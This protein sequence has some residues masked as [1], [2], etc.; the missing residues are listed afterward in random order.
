VLTSA[1]ILLY[2]WAS[3]PELLVAHMGGPFFAHKDE[4][5]WSIPKGLADPGEDHFAAA[6]REFGEEMGSPPPDADYLDLGTIRQS[7]KHVRIWAAE[8]EFDASTAVSN[9]FELEWP[10]RSGRIREFPE[11]DRAAWFTPDDARRKLVTSQLPFV[12]RL[13]AALDNAAG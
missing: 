13:L 6:R 10:P 3:G 9:T 4:R 8:G 2:R 11:M 1:G 12:D 7:S 5:A